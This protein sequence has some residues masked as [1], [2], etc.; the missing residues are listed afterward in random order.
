MKI[1]F[2]KKVIESALQK[3][4]KAVSP[5]SP[6]PILGYVLVKTEGK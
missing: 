3:V 1:Q 2:D 6:L 4:I 5:R